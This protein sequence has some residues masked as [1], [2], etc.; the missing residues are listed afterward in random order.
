MVRHLAIHI[1]E[2]LSMSLGRPAAIRPGKP[3]YKYVF[4]RLIEGEDFLLG[5]LH[6]GN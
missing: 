4:E 2:D 1:A 6:R 3:V 5:I